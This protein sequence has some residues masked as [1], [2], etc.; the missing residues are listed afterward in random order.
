MI[1]AIIFDMDDLIV[2]SDPLHSIAWERVLSDFGKSFDDIPSNKKSKFIGMRVID[3]CKEIINILGLDIDLNTF[4]EKRTKVFLEI[5]KS[6]L[7]LMPGLLES[8]E[9]FSSNDYKIALAS[10]GAKK[11]IDLVLDKFNIR[12][13]FD[14]IVSGD[15]VSIGKPHPETYIVASKMLNLKAE[16]CV[17]LEDA[18]NGIISAIQ[19]GCKC[20]A[21]HNPHTPYQN[22]SEATLSISSLKDINLDIISKI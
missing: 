21:V 13:Y 3:I 4:Y 14:I 18:E 2:N 22:L 11:Y 17:V 5:V 16:E 20:I 6:E 15:N 1:K 10:S 12:K 8:L 7:E 9:L 19:A